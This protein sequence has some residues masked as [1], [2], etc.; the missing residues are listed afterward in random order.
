MIIVDVEIRKAILGRGEQPR[1]GIEYCE[2]WRDFANM[3][4]ACVCTLD[5]ETSL[6]RLFTQRLLE[7]LDQYLAGQ[8]VGG[9]NTERFDFELLRAQGLKLRVAEHYDVLRQIWIALGLDPDRFEPATHGGWSLDAVAGNT[10][11]ATKSG[12]GALAPVWWQ[13]GEHGRVIDYCLRDVWLEA[14]LVQWIAERG[15]VT[16]GKQTVRLPRPPGTSVR[17]LGVAA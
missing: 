9:F 3:G 14:R 6:S 4:V 17:A 2:G 16:N 13:Q 7:D 5:T 10:L 8:V 1:E 12:N 15:D 11:G